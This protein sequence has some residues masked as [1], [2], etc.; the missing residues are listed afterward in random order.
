M[1]QD[2]VDEE[3]VM[4]NALRSR[5][6]SAARL[7]LSS[8]V[9]TALAPA[10]GIAAHRSPVA[11]RA[12]SAMSLAADAGNPYGN[13]D[14]RN[15]AG[16]DTGDSEVERLNEGQLDQNYRGP[17]SYRLVPPGYAPRPGYAPPAGYAPQPGYYAQPPTYAPQSGYAVMPGR[18]QPLP[19][20]PPP[21]PGYR[22]SGY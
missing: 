15:D 11:L 16:N 19:G 14:R 20:S 2:I 4:P 13:V 3:T 22:G 18:P 7:A 9:G 17:Y 12:P 6:A 8:L 1:W 5:A 21:P 10:P